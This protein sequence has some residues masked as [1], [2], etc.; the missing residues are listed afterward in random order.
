MNKHAF[1][2]I[3]HNEPY[4]LK[5]Q[6]RLLD[7]P[8]HDIYLH[9][10]LRAQELAYEIRQIRLQHASLYMLPHPQ[11]VYWGDLSQVEVEYRLFETA[12]ERGTYAYYHLLS[13]TDLPLKTPAEMHRF[14][15]AHQGKEF[16]GFWDSPSHRRDLERKVQRYYL[17]TP[18][19]KGGGRLRHSVTSL[20]RNIVLAVQKVTRYRRYP[21]CEFRKGF[22]WVSITSDFCQ[23]LIRHKTEVLKRFRYTLCPDEIFIQSLI[24]NSPFRPNIYCTAEAC[25]GSMR[26]IDWERGHPYV[27]TAADLDELRRSPYMFARKFSTKHSEAIQGLVQ[28]LTTPSS[29]YNSK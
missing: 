18:Y 4:V 26:L 23:Y 19:L 14:F 27:W 28:H 15:D 9:I 2:I 17:F 16:V 21:A 6:L 12:F 29:L 10:D 20:V 5:E 24:W 7:D 3:A 11:A 22:Q 1:L 8:A 25:K 13:G